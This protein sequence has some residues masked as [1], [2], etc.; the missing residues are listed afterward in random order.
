MLTRVTDLAGLHVAAGANST[1]ED[2]CEV[3]HALAES[4]EGEWPAALERFESKRR[5]RADLV[6]WYAV[7][8]SLRAQKRPNLPDLDDDVI[9]EFRRYLFTY[10]ETPDIRPPAALVEAVE[11]SDIFADLPD[12]VYQ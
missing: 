4:E 5:A 10:P 7:W 12:I 6:H 2:A 3:A 8:T 9:E 1:F 11:A